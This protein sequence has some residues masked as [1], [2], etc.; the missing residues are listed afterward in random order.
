MIIKHIEIENFRCYE[1]QEFHFSKGANIILG[2]NN[3]GKSKLFD[4]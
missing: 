3:S 1:K 4:N 2:Q